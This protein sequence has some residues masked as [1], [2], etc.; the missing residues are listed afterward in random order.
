SWRDAGLWLVVVIGSVGCV[1]ELIQLLF[2]DAGMARGA[3]IGAML[4][5]VA[6]RLLNLPVTTCLPA[7]QAASMA[8]RLHRLGYAERPSIRSRTFES[9]APRWL[10]WDSNTVVICRDEA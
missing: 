1:A 4:A 5:A 8:A 6:M 7:A 9:T 3:A 2:D 10:R